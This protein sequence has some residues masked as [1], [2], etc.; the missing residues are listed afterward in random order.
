MAAHINSKGIYKALGGIRTSANN[1]AAHA[2]KLNNQ[3]LNFEQVLQQTQPKCIKTCLQNSQKELENLLEN[4]KNSQDA[5]TKNI[6]KDSANIIARLRQ[7]VIMMY[8][9]TLK[10]PL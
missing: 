10:N 1:L 9:I 7:E 4:I 5:I 3:S 2:S 8:D 6:H